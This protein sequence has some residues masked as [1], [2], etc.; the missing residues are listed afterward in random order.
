MIAT[1]TSAV[2]VHVAVR[3]DSADGAACG[4]GEAGAAA[5]GLAV[6]LLAVAPVAG[7]ALGGSGTG[8]RNSSGSRCD[9]A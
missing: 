1:R 3:R 9:G 8:V 2:T 5:A 4:V 6:G 7:G